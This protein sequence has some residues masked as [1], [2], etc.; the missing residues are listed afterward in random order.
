MDQDAE[1][2][3]R[4]KELLDQDIDDLPPGWG[5]ELDSSR[6]AYYY[7][8]ELTGVSQ[9]TCPTAPAQSSMTEGSNDGQ[10]DEGD[11]DAP[12]P[13]PRRNDCRCSRHG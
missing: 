7:V 6:N 3:Q 8:N 1:M 11:A 12:P 10:D 2:L 13:P 9:W 4:K 5:V